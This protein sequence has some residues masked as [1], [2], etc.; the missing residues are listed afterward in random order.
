MDVRVRPWMWE[1]DREEG[2][3]FIWKNDCSCPGTGNLDMK[4]LKNNLGKIFEGIELEL[5]QFT[6]S[7][8]SAV[9]IYS[10]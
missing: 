2:W 10:V 1:L 9:T 8:S 3:I 5:T 7:P 6:N 4:I